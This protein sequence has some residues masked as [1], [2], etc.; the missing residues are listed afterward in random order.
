MKIINI[1]ETAFREGEYIIGS[2]QTHSHACYL[3]YGTLDVGQ[4]RVM[5]ASH[6]HAEIFCLMAG[7]GVAKN[8][9]DEYELG[10]GQCFYYEGDDPIEVI[11]TGTET[12]V[13]VIAGGHTHDTEH[14]H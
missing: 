14:H 5:H 7:S 1:K 8:A 12:I 11:N 2:Q 9:G 13:Y 6:G 10:R 4:S 3:L